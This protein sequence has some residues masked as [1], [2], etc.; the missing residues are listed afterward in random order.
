MCNL[1]IAPWLKSSIQMHHLPFTL[2]RDTL[3][4]ACWGLAM[5]TLN[6]QC[7]TTNLQTLDLQK[8]KH[9]FL[10][11]IKFILIK[12]KK[13]IS[14][15]FFTCIPTQF[16]TI[17]IV[18]WHFFLMFLLVFIRFTEQAHDG[19]LKQFI[20]KD[21]WRTF[22]LLHRERKSQCTKTKKAVWKSSINIYKWPTNGLK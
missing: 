10:Q 2:P 9:T 22:A 3:H 17:N 6:V 5:A 15:V 21:T 16:I 13:K 20:W 12:R 4:I 19:G 11:N 14:F 8:W 18:Q 1:C 7:R